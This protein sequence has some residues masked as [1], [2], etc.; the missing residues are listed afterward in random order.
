MNHF[1]GEHPINVQGSVVCEDDLASWS[2]YGAIGAQVRETPD[3]TEGRET[4]MTKELIG[5]GPIFIKKSS[6]FYTSRRVIRDEDS[7]STYNNINKT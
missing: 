5:A 7:E 4:G 2:A 1:I 6:E 3:I